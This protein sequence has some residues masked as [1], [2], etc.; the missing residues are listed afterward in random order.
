M[1][2]GQSS[3]GVAILVEFIGNHERFGLGYEPTHANV[4]RISL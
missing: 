2:L 3:N 1:G 4:R